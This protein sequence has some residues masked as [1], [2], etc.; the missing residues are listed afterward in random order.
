MKYKNTRNDEGGDSASPS[1]HSCAE[2]EG[3]YYLFVE[4]SHAD[5][6]V[7]EVINPSTFK[8]FPLL[9]N[10]SKED[11]QA[12]FPHCPAIEDDHLKYY[13]YRS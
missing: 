1:Y 6:E 13:E 5:S 11:V 3:T 2:S 9:R 8:F 12:L 7:A 10:R 4:L